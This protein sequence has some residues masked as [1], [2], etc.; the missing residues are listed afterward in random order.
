MP[1]LRRTL[2]PGWYS[3]V[4]V[5]IA[6]KLRM[7][8]GRKTDA[9]DALIPRSRE[10]IRETIDKAIIPHLLENRDGD[11]LPRD[12]RISP[13]WSP[14]RKVIDSDMVTEFAGHLVRSDSDGALAMVEQ[15]L[16]EGISDEALCTDLLTPAARLLGDWWVKD[17]C[18]F[19][20]VTLGLLLL[21]DVLHRLRENREPESHAEGSA[22]EVLFIVPPGEQHILGLTM[23]AD[24][25]TRA[26]WTTRLEFP[27][28]MADVADSV[29]QSHAQIVGLT[30]SS[31]AAFPSLKTAISSVR[32]H[33]G[34]D[35]AHIMVGGH[36]FSA[37]PDLVS[38]A[39]ADTV[40]C[41]TRHALEIAARVSSGLPVRA[42][43]NSVGTN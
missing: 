1:R 24:F 25:F 28:T 27:Q 14:V 26:S 12:L 16:D 40:A 4:A 6:D 39:G 3:T 11:R 19:A 34:A 32:N 22:G 37:E 38:E 41:D 5:T 42:M 8:T 17:Q 18:G 2:S 9:I 43:G 21:H 35:A 7:I 30:C 10:D 36:V 20:E 13:L 33:M 15:L 29:A 31:K 23:V